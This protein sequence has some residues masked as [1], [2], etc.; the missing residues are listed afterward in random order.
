MMMMMSVPM[1]MYMLASVVVEQ[2]Q[3]RWGGAASHVRSPS[4]P[5]PY[6]GR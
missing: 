6:A 3:L 2:R 1:P 4:T 5:A